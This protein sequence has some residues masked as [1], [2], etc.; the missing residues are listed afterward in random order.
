MAKSLNIEQRLERLER[1][2]AAGMININVRQMAEEDVMV[3]YRVSKSYLKQ[4]RNG[5][6]KKDG[7][8]VAPKLFKWSHRNGRDIMYDVDEL[9]QVFKRQTIAV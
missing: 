8:V 7:T 3:V 1:M 5:Y 9:N 4:L 6:T 2:W